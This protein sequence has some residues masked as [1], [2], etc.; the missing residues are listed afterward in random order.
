MK[1]KAII[2]ALI[3]L[4]LLPSGLTAQT[5]SAKVKNKVVIITINAVT[6]E[7][8]LAFKGENISGLIRNGA[9]GIM[10][11]RSAADLTPG[12]YYVTIGAGARA[13]AGSY[14]A[15]GFNAQEPIRQN[16]YD[17]NL[18]AMEVFRQNIG[19]SVSKNALVNIGV[20]D[21]GNK[22][23]RS[24]NSVRPGLLG[25]KLEEA[26]KR[27]AAI[28]NADTMEQV[29]REIA[30]VT[31]NADGVTHMGDV[32]SAS[33]KLD[34]SFPGGY[35]TNFTVLAQK[36]HKYLGKADLL[37]IELGDSSRLNTRRP[38]MKKSQYKNK[39]WQS[40]QNA[41][42]FVGKL[43]EEVDIDNSLVIITSPQARKDY[44][45]EKN[46]LSPIII[47][48]LGR[49]ALASGT[50]KRVGL[51][52]NIDLAPTILNYFNLA[53][54]AEMAGN[55]IKSIPDEDSTS[56][57]NKFYDQAL[58]IR[59]VRK[60]FLI[61]YLL[62]TLI[63]TTL[64]LI[65]LFKID[66]K[67]HNVLI[68]VLRFTSLFLIALPAAS[69][70][71][72]P[73]QKNNFFISFLSLLFFST[74]FS[75]LAYYLFK[76]KKL[77]GLL[78]LTGSTV[79]II[80]ADSF[81]G[82]QFS[83]HSYFG[84]DMSA[85]GRYYGL[86]NTLMG[87]LIGSGIYFSVFFG[88]RFGKVKSWPRV[89]FAVLS[90]LFLS[91]L[92]GHPNLGAN[93]GGMITGLGTT[94]VCGLVLSGKK[95]SWKLVGAGLILLIALFVSILSLDLIIGQG[96]THSS[97]ALVLIKTNGP[98]AVTDIIIRKLLQNIRGVMGPQGIV[99][100]GVIVALGFLKKYI[101]R[102]SKAYKLIAERY[103]ALS[104]IL[105]ISYWAAAIGFLFND[106]GAAAAIAVLMY[107]LTV[108]IYIFLRDELKITA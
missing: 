72:L 7:D 66:D 64:S 105:I 86:G 57:V 33:N 81:M 84:S 56:L 23:F 16:N 73:L 12:D 36:A 63:V 82:S 28:G 60:S 10:N 107:I 55:K 20:I 70:F 11:N 26:G 79:A 42:R 30:L 6:L 22:S 43:L 101:N 31:M 51:I 67:Q 102:E 85:G 98:S 99:L 68:K 27:T 78:F 3:C 83:L 108:F 106:T 41:D 35:R 97:K 2:L 65:S 71:Q 1:N 77:R 4:I 29:H 14:G 76:D 62:I 103:P 61:I 9:I 5:A 96:Q 46:F 93:I 50:T 90:V 48:G 87:V 34:K 40:I 69:F 17:G 89:L 8:I 24:H 37:V 52:S 91:M 18:Q 38:L 53:I 104:K 13:N 19:K 92:I 47:S 88:E 100:A 21:A 15:M 95:P 74:V 44:I 75:L 58:S 80:A 32:S 39:I 49:G 54:P 94:L 45:S 25:Q 59:Q